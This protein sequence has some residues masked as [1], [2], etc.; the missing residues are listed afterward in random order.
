[1]DLRR[2][3]RIE[4]KLPVEVRSGGRKVQCYSRDIS[5]HGLYVLTD[6]PPA[7]RQLLALRINLPD[8]PLPV[9]VVGSV[10]HR[11]TR[12]DSVRTGTAA[13]MGIGFF[14]LSGEAKSRW[15]GYVESLIGHAPHAPG[16]TAKSPA[17]PTFLLRLRD[18]QRVREF[19]Q[20]E[21]AQGR[22]F[23][24]TPVLRPIGDLVQL[25]VIHPITDDELALACRVGEVSLG[26]PT[27]AKGMTL[28][29][30]ALDEALVRAF[31]AFLAGESSPTPEPSA[32]TAEAPPAVPPPIELAEPVALV[33]PP[34]VP[35]AQPSPTAGAQSHPALRQAVARDPDAIGPKLRLA[36]ALAQHREESAE[37]IVLL[38][39]LLVREPHHPLAHSSLALA[40]AQ[41]GD[42]SEAERHLTRALRL[43]HVDEEI[44]RRVRGVS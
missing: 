31:G 22:M 40:Y 5:R 37:A 8:G 10:A 9:D 41:L 43:G 28:E 20:K 42:R 21:L 1:M 6:N 14:V 25:V 44:E 16:A 4:V 36:S 24:K 35:A 7:E 30:P 23:L 18:L 2:C 38:R 26:S 17:K 34:P 15:D 29:L 39:E 19:Q 32:P 11:V 3:Q 12:E 33:E 27:Q 13:G